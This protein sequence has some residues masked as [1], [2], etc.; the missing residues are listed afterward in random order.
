MR[1]RPGTREDCPQIKVVL[2]TLISC[3]SVKLTVYL[4]HLFCKLYNIRDGKAEKFF[5][6]SASPNCKM[7]KNP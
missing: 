7:I 2:I 6:L 1:G 3:L 5:F 4:F